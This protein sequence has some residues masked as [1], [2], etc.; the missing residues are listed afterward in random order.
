MGKKRDHLAL[1]A[2]SPN[3]SV[4]TNALPATL[5]AVV[6][7]PTVF[8]CARPTALLTLSAS[9]T[10][11]TDARPSTVLARVPQPAVFTN[12]LPS[13][14]LAITALPTMLTDTLPS[15]VL[16]LAPLSAMRTEDLSV[17]I[18][19]HLF[20]AFS[21]MSCSVDPHAPSATVTLSTRLMLLLGVGSGGEGAFGHCDTLSVHLHTLCSLRDHGQRDKTD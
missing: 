13:A 8:T 18:S 20:C 1:L 7:T 12:S 2:E 14:L 10:M 6:T 9:P 11:L 3:L 15:A 19:L 5:L 17:S 4:N 21:L 16:T